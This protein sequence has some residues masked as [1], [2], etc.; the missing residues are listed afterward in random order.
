MAK[1][2][3]A[4]VV[5]EERCKGCNL[6][7][8]SCPADVLELQPQMMNQKGYHYVYMKNP[9]DCIGCANCGYVCPDACLTVYR[10]K[11]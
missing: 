9:D 5:N 11:S 7:V 4:V 3:G 6:C 10:M 1:V 8:V 2:K